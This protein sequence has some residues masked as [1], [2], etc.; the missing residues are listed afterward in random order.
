VRQGAARRH[1]GLQSDYGKTGS[2]W[3]I[4]FELQHAKTPLLILWVDDDQQLTCP[5]AV[6]WV[7][8]RG[9]LCV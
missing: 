5:L 6:L 8:T 1:C 4:F 7:G 9:L 2:Q 3:R